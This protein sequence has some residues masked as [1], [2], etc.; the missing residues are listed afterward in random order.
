M[1]SQRYNASR[2]IAIIW[3]RVCGIQNQSK[4]KGT[5]ISQEFPTMRENVYRRQVQ[6]VVLT[7][8]GRTSPAH[9]SLDALCAPNASAHLRHVCAQKKCI[10]QPNAPVRRYDEKILV[11]CSAAPVRCTRA[12]NE[13][14]SRVVAASGQHLPKMNA[15]LRQKYTR[16]AT[17]RTQTCF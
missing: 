16:H 12:F 14:A 3:S 5:R 15:A 2:A 8:P 1:R 17:T 7:H 13:K 10:M 4:S 11:C 9:A 6:D